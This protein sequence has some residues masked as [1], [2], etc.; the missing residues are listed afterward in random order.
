MVNNSSSSSSS[1]GIGLLGMTFIV[2]LFLKLAGHITWSWW[3]ITAPLWGGVVLG[4]TVVTVIL[5]IAFIIA[6]FD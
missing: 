4:F 6:L 2:L 3:W 1:A 5:L